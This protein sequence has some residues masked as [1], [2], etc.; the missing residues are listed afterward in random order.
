MATASSN[1]PF[2]PSEPTSPLV[3]TEIPGPNSQA[4][5]KDLNTVFDTN[6]VNMLTDFDQS[7]GN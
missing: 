6:N 2:F 1:A 4:I 3:K 5:L 7:I